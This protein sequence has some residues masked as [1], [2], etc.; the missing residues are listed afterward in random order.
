MYA[1]R[2]LPAQLVRLHLVDIVLN[3]HDTAIREVNYAVGHAADDRIMRNH[4]GRGTG[5]DIYFADGIEHG[6]TGG[7]IQ[8]AGWFVTQ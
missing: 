5:L 8:R 2:R 3:I 1:A 4:D 6:D 7:D